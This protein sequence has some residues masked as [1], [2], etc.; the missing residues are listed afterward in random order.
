MLSKTEIRIFT[1]A[2]ILAT[3]FVG[4]KKA[5]A[6]QPAE[7][8]TLNTFFIQQQEPVQGETYKVQTL[9]DRPKIKGCKNPTWLFEKSGSQVEPV[10]EARCKNGKKVFLVGK[11]N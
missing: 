10:F 1:I 8:K 6:S 2:L 5:F 4:T 7:T 9:K 11:K 3:C